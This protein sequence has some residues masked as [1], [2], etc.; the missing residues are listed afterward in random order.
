MPGLHAPPAATCGLGCRTRVLWSPPRSPGLPASGPIPGKGPRVSGRTRR[1]PGEGR[2][3]R[4]RRARRSAGKVRL[5]CAGSGSRARRAPCAAARART[6]SSSAR[7]R[8]SAALPGSAAPRPAPP[9]AE[10]PAL[11][12]RAADLRSLL[13]AAPGRA[14]WGGG[15]GEPKSQIK[16][17][18]LSLE[19]CQTAQSNYNPWGNFFFF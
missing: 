7:P 11:P 8:R 10:T 14:R 15:G 5:R 18:D 19:R 17:L 12:R 6:S 13:P 3:L 16:H 2:L 4:G 1:L 9:S